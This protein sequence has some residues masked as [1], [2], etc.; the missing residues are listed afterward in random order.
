VIYDTL[1]ILSINSKCKIITCFRLT[2]RFYF[3][4]TI[5][6][7]ILIKYKKPKV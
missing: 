3:K 1:L 2:N 4:I 7:V 5:Y 6:I